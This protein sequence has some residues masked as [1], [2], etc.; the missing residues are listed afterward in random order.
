MAFELQADCYAGT[1]GR[2]AAHEPEVSMT[3]R[4][5]ALL[6]ATLGILIL[7][8]LGGS[9]AIAAPP[10]VIPISGTFHD[11]ILSDACGVEVTTAFNG[12]VRV[13]EFDRQTGLAT[14][15]TVNVALTATADDRTF[16]FRDVGADVLLQRG[17]GLVHLVIGQVPFEF[18]GVLKINETTGEILLE[19]Q[20]T[21]DT[22]RAC[23]FLTS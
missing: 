22:E 20:H 23:A 9:R 5:L 13:R 21:V 10:Q 18:T 19:P 12:T 15:A 1:W 6:F 14:V 17:E 11:D 7:V 3:R 4:R 8:G 2:R 16:R